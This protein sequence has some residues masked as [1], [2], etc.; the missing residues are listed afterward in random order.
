MLLGERGNSKV[1]RKFSTMSG[2]VQQLES[3]LHADDYDTDT[4]WSYVEE[5][6]QTVGIELKLAQGSGN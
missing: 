4:F 5:C 2:L 1:S 3:G 6:C